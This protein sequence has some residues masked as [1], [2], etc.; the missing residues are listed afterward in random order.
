MKVQK[1]LNIAV[2]AK[3]LINTPSTLISSTNSWKNLCI[4]ILQG[5]TDEKLKWNELDYGGIEKLNMA[6]H[7]IWQPDMFLY[8]R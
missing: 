3:L 7:E 5:W 4:R 2:R 1:Y 6:D 8:N